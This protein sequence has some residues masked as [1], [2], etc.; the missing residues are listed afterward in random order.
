M[1][2]RS[3]SHP[4]PNAGPT[5]EEAQWYSPVGHAREQGS[6]HRLRRIFVDG[7]QEA[8]RLLTDK[9]IVNLEPHHVKFRNWMLDQL[10]LAAS[11]KQGPGS[12]GW[13]SGGQQ[14][15]EG[16]MVCHLG[17]HLVT[18]LRKE[19]PPLEIMMEGRLLYRYYAMPCVWGHHWCSLPA[20]CGLSFTKTRAPV[21]LRLVEVPETQLRTCP[22]RSTVPS[23]AAHMPRAGTSPTFLRFFEA[24]R[25]ESGEFVAEL[26]ETGCRVAAMSCDVSIASHLAQSLC[27]CKNQGLL[28][29]RGVTQGAMV[30]QDSITGYMA[31]DDWQTYIVPKVCGTRNLHVQCSNP[32]ALDFFIILSSFSGHLGLV[33]QANYAAGSAYQ[34]ALARQR[35][36]H[37]L[38]GVAIDFGAVRGVGYVAK[39][40]GVADRMRITGEILMLSETAVHNALQAAIAHPVRHPQILLNLNTGPGPQWYP[41]ELAPERMPMLGLKII[42]AKLAAILMLPAD[43]IDLRQSST[44]YSVD[45]L[46]AVELRKML[47]LQASTDVSIFN[48]MQSSSLEALAIDIAL[49]SK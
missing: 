34:D 33:T 38:P 42:A 30:L 25:A 23:R 43:D 41:Q 29:V 20:C 47:V 8:L 28:P 16:E 22:G 44:Q 21:S 9:D 10:S 36:A 37:G 35:S 31:L 17:P 4:A 7:C 45:S 46:V 19:R 14:E 1:A 12:E 27:T 18:I 15:R 40:A 26:R 39:T 6:C 48:I 2:A 13:A 5:R 11:G 49:K 3:I 32:E 24:A